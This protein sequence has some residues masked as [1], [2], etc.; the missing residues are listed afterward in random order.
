M[1]LSDQLFLKLFFLFYFSELTFSVFF[2][3]FFTL[4]PLRIFS[5]GF[6]PHEITLEKAS[7]SSGFIHSSDPFH[8]S[9]CRYHFFPHALYHSALKF[10][11]PGSAETLEDLV[12]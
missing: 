5:L 3:L 10:E 8:P 6:N 11:A 12:T 9:L 4:L 2:S 7:Y 1:F